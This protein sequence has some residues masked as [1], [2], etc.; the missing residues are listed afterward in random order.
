MYDSQKSNNTKEN[1]LGKMKIEEAGVIQQKCLEKMRKG[2]LKP[3]ERMDCFADFETTIPSIE[4]VKEFYDVWAV[5]YDEDMSVVG[6]KNPTDV[7][8]VLSTLVAPD[9]RKDLKILDLGAGTGVGG[10]K[11]VEAGF[12]NIDATDGSSGMLEEARKLGVYGNVLQP[13]VLVKGQRM[14][15]VQPETYDVITSSGSFYPFHLQGHHLK[16]FLDDVK[17]EGLLV[18]SACP[19]SDKDIGLRPVID[20]LVKDAVIEVVKEIYVPDWYRE[21]DGTVWVLKKLKRLYPS[22]FM[23]RLEDRRL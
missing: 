3:M 2:G 21:D 18:I 4:L 23:I 22:A 9:E 6:Y 8:E 11:L 7:A 20:E 16:C 14:L 13:E 19:N 5:D 1:L 10:A 17:T 15:T 12:T